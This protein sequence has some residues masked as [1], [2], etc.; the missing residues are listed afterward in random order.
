MLPETHSPLFSNTDKREPHSRH[1][2][3]AAISTPLVE[4]AIIARPFAHLLHMPIRNALATCLLTTCLIPNGPA[5]MAAGTSGAPAIGSTTL[6]WKEQGQTADVTVAEGPAIDGRRSVHYRVE[7]AASA[8]CHAVF[9]GNAQFYSTTDDA[10]DT[11]VALPNGNWG[12]LNQFRDASAN[13]LVDIELDIDTA[14]PRFV[15]F[16]LEHPSGAAPRCLGAEGVGFMVFAG[17]QAKLS[18]PPRKQAGKPAATYANVRYAYTID[19]PDDLL[20]AGREA[21]NSDGVVFS[22]KSGKTQVAVWGRFNANEDTPAQILHSEEELPCA[23]ARASY[24]VSK[25]DLVAFSCQ[26]PKNE[27]VYEKMIIHGDTLVAV[28]FTYPVAEQATWSP[29]IKQMAG[30]LRIE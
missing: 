9:E 19:Y 26:T 10:G 2:S 24:E 5:C 13:G 11:S 25:R 4:R 17:P 18:N 14:H 8:Q 29:V 20:F 28:Q 22:A 21:D 1:A 16:V 3:R 6:H 27:I 7:F 15:D 12:T 23:G 30:S